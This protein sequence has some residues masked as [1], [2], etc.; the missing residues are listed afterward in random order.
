MPADPKLAALPA[1]RRLAEEQAREEYE[2]Y[3]RAYHARYRNETLR[4]WGNHHGDRDCEVVAQLA[5]LADLSRPASRDAVARLVAEAAC[6][7]ITSMHLY[8]SGAVDY[9]ERWPASL[10]DDLT[11]D[12]EADLTLAALHFLGAA[13]G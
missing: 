2:A 13:N 7:N 12:G 11:G 5:L 6:E 9:P 4:P 10:L 1:I 8:L 3:G